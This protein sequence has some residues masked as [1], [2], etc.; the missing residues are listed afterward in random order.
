MIFKITNV[1]A[2]ENSEKHRLVI[3]A[4]DRFATITVDTLEGFDFKEGLKFKLG[5]ANAETGSKCTK[6]VDIPDANLEEEGDK[7]YNLISSKGIKLVNA[8]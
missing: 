1:K 3:K 8:E 6:A 7:F 2:I 4:N 5:K